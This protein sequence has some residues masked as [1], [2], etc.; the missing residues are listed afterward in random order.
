MRGNHACFNI[1]YG[2]NAGQQLSGCQLVPLIAQ[3]LR[4]VEQAGS[5]GVGTFAV[6]LAKHPG[7]TVATT[8]STMNVDWLNNLGADVVIDYKKDDFANILH[9]C[10]VVL[11][12]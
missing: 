1:L 10:D 2:P 9:D 5:G 4:E 8:T 12:S 3:S 11:N 7:A 6:Q